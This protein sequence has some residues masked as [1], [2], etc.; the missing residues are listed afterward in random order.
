MGSLAIAFI[1]TTMKHCIILLVLGLCAYVQAGSWVYLEDA[2][3]APVRIRRSPQNDQLQPLQR[4][5]ERRQGQAAAYDDQQLAGSSAYAPGPRGKVGPV[6]T[7]VK[8]DPK[9]N[10][11]WGVRH[12]A[13][14]QYGK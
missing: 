3:D 12:V 14:V 13:G 10:F 8:T 11:K 5:A 4:I 1:P 9:A 6:Y 2:H 7:F